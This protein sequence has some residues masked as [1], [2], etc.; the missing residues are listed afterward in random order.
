ME[1]FNKF[2]RESRRFDTKKEMDL[3]FFIPTNFAPYA[4]ARI[5]SI[6]KINKYKITNDLENADVIFSQHFKGPVTGTAEINKKE[7]KSYIKNKSQKTIHKLDT[8][9]RLF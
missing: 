8:G 2:S 1:E 6:S 9:Y 7:A 3:K 5:R 4:K